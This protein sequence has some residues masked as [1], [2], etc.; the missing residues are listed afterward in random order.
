M[1][2]YFIFSDV[3]AQYDILLLGLYKADF[4]L[5][6]PEHIMII[7]GDLL[8]RGKQGHELIRFLEPL[9][10]DGRVL[11]V[12][13]NHDLFLKEILED[14]HKIDHIAFNIQHNGFK[15]TLLLAYPGAP[16]D[17]RLN[18]PNL[19]LIKEN[20]WATY[21]IF[22]KWLVALPLYLEFGHHVIVH[23]FLDFSLQ[24]WRKTKTAYAVWERGY[25]HK[26]PGGFTKR[27]IIGHTPNQYINGE[28]DIITDGQ[29]IMI[30]GGAAYGYQ[31]NMLVLTEEEL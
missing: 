13:G 23:G 7:G 20:F 8:D 2:K 9:I 16:K 24:D 28:A 10:E 26:V 18:K 12:L 27:L 6:N 5:S 30:D 3:H 22:S 11:G 1:K 25:D 14:D 17:F 29:K 15:E 31:V 4:N 21:P 19:S